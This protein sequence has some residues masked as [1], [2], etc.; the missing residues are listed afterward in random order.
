M[1]FHADDTQK[2]SLILTVVIE[3]DDKRVIKIRP[4]KGKKEEYVDGDEQ[5]ELFI[6]GG[7]GYRMNGMC[8]HYII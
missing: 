2:E 1:G 8:H 4:K 3:S 7:D 5:I 6:K